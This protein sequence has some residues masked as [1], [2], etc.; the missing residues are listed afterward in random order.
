M[1]CLCGLL[2]PASALATTAGPL[3]ELTVGPANTTQRAPVLAWDP[4]QST[5]VIVWQDERSAANGTDLYAARIGSDGTIHPNDTSGCAIITNPTQV[6]GDESQPAVV[7]LGGG[8]IAVAWLEARTGVNDIYATRLMTSNCTTVAN[9]AVTSGADAEIRPALSVSAQSLLISYQVTL[10]S[11][12]QLI[13]GRRYSLSLAALDGAP[14]TLSGAGAA[15]PSAL[16]VGAEHLVA[17]DMG[18]DVF[19]KVV[20]STGP[21]APGNAVTVANANLSQSRVSLAALGSGGTVALWQDARAGSS[22][23]DIYGRR[24]S[25]S[26]V[27]A[28]AEVQTS[29][30]I[31]AQLSP[32]ASGDGNR[33]FAVWQDRRNSSINAIIY[34]TRLDPSTGAALDASGFPVLVLP[35][36]AFEATVTKGPNGDYLVAAV[37]FGNPTRI[38]Y[39]ILRDEAPSGTMVASGDTSAPADNVTA[40]NLTLG[41]AVGPS[42]LPVVDGTL[43]TVTL[44]QAAA[45]LTQSDADLTLP[46]HQVM[47]NGGQVRVSVVSPQVGPCMVDVA[48]VQGNASGNTQAGFTNGPPSANQVQISP[49]APTSLVDLQLSYTFDDPN[50]D[51]ESGTSIQWTRNAAVQPNYADMLVIPAS[52]TRQGEQWR[53]RVSPSDGMAIGM[54][55]FSNSVTVINAAPEATMVRIEP[56][57]DVRRGTLLNG[58]YT[59]QDPD[60]DVESGTQTRWFKDN[61]EQSNLRNTP[62][63]QGTSLTKGQVWRFD[64][65]ASDGMSQGPWTASAPV[66]VVNS[67]PVAR[68]GDEGRVPE[69][70]RYMLDGRGSSDQDAQDSLQYTWSQLIAGMDPAV[71][72]SSTSSVTPSFIAPDVDRETRLTFQLVVSDGEDISAAARVQVI[73]EAAQ[74]QDGDGLDDVQEMQLG[75]DPTRA[76]TD[77]DGLSDREERDL[78]TQPL[79]QDSDDDG[80]RD[81]AEGR[82]CKDCTDMDPTADPDG[83]QRIAALDPDSDDDGLMDGTELAVRAPISPGGV[84]PYAYLGTDESAGSFAPD[85]DP[86]SQTH[87]LKA[88]T[89]GD[90]L[91][92]GT[93]DL[94]HNG[95]LDDGES[96]PND[97]E[98]PGASCSD[99]RPCPGRLVCEGGICRAPPQTDGG[100][101]QCTAQPDSVMCCNGGCNGGTLTDAICLE[102]GARETCPVGSELCVAG[103][104][105]VTNVPTNPA[106]TGGCTSGPGP[107]AL[108]WALLPGWLYFRRRRSVQ[109]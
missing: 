81:G 41:P 80:V 107:G 89:D 40:V 37:L 32:R 75:T 86:D 3:L 71:L 103:A 70:G 59:Y 21:I 60:S 92:D 34:G 68:A 45:S 31:A 25:A 53:A 84:A 109:P 49:V 105:A 4:G 27:P 1:G 8:E 17:W 99:A 55:A 29:G 6:V 64:V 100:M 52:A 61:Q 19:A 22:N 74:D 108:I 87:V 95:R 77:L 78:G 54:P 9:I 13:K 16:S 5:Y 104:C 11:G 10:V 69:R 66:T 39:R 42:G 101:S 38:Y 23:E 18:G 12:S 51:S 57:S 93:E 82:S 79:D 76:D 15:R 33:A 14:T 50:G 35:G 94:N 97:P 58:R 85:L 91:S 98:D 67:I 24:Y 30:A 72:L 83:D 36:N 46:G 26:L 102:P 44:S 65:Q 7:A 48:S 106:P 47:A 20:P 62:R 43:Y 28:A 73:V 63:V 88:D 56:D 90:S 96:D 2:A